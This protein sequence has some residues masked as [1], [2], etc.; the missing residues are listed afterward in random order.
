AFD[1][2]LMILTCE[3]LQLVQQ[4]DEV[5]ETVRSTKKKGDFYTEVKPFADKMKALS[6]EWEAEAKKWLISQK[7]KYIHKQQI[8]STLENLQII[9]VQA[10]FPQT[11]YSRFKQ[12]I[13]SVEYILNEVKRNVDNGESSK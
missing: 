9:A 11:S 13:R 8:T 10:F 6:D 5:Y 1:A 7:P 12:A 4:A 2:K 3:L